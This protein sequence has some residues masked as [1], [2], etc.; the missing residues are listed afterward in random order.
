MQPRCSIPAS[1]KATREYLETHHREV[2][3]EA[4]DP[5]DPESLHSGSAKGIVVANSVI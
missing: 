1:G 2:A 5:K 3:I 4:K